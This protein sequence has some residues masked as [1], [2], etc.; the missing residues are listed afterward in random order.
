MPDIRRISEISGIYESILKKELLRLEAAGRRYDTRKYEHF[1]PIADSIDAQLEEILESIELTGVQ[2]RHLLD[3]GVGRGKALSFLACCLQSS[4][5]G[6]DARP[7]AVELSNNVFARMSQEGILDATG[8]SAYHG[9]FFPPDYPVDSRLKWGGMHR[10]PV[11]IENFDVYK[12]IGL[13]LRDF[14]MVYAHQFRSNGAAIFRLLSERCAP[15]T[16]IAAVQNPA[17]EVPLNIVPVGKG[18][19][20]VLYSISG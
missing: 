7:L 6:I 17:A 12:G 13:G 10:P 18:A 2:I 14:D 16:L 8:C 19:H 4:G 3:L 11:E 20:T 9:N 15:G 5:F 1:F